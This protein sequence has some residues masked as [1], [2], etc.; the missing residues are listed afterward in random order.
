VPSRPSYLE[1]QFAALNGRP[2]VVVSDTHFEDTYEIYAALARHLDGAGISTAILLEGDRPPRQGMVQIAID[3]VDATDAAD[4]QRRFGFSLFKPLVCERSLTDYCTFRRDETYSRLT[5]EQFMNRYSRFVNAYDHLFSRGGAF[6]GMLHDTFKSAVASRIAAQYGRPILLPIQ[7]YWWPDGLLFYDTPM[8]GAREIERR[9]QYYLSR[10]DA[11]DR[12]RADAIYAGKAQTMISKAATRSSLFEKVT[13]ALRSRTSP[14]PF[15]LRRFAKRRAGRAT[16]AVTG[17]LRPDY[18]PDRAAAA[19]PFVL[20]PMH[21]AP[22]ASILGGAPE[23]AD[24]FS[25][26]KN[27]SINLPLGTRLLVKEHPDQHRPRLGAT[28]YRQIASL[29]NVALVHGSARAMNLVRM[30]ECLAVAVINGTLGLEAAYEGKRVLLPERGAAWYS[31]CGAF[32]IMEEWED[33]FR[34][35]SSPI[36]AERQRRDVTALFLA[37]DDCVEPIERAP[38][39]P[40]TFRAAGQAAAQAIAH[41]AE[42]VLTTTLTTCAG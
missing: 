3:Q 35:I 13:N 14:E 24:Q 17:A 2:F 21:V 22:E 23:Y 5:V 18:L 20:Y 4:L 12:S 30:R 10:P 26:I 37:M 40:Y 33:V 41:K 42:K 28:F 16:A 7:Y 32:D 36:D 29:P 31:F 34:A 38:T 9:Y 11:I 6:V 15:S 27:I 25:L 19:T 1:R 39:G 8:Q